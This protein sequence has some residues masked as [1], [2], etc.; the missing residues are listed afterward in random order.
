MS[1]LA[2]YEHAIAV[3]TMT[4]VA[5]QREVL[6]H[7]QR[8]ADALT[9][10][11]RRFP[12]QRLAQIQGIYLHGPV[13]SGK[14][15]LVDMLLQQLQGVAVG[16]FHFHQFMQQ[17]DA[18]L[19]ALQ[20]QSDPLRRIVAQYAKTT[21]LLCL[22]EF[23][24]Q[25]VAHAMMLAELLKALAAHEVVLVATSNTAPEN[26]YLNGVQRDR[27]LPAIALLQTH[28]EVLELVS[29]Q[30]F[31]LK[32]TAGSGTWYMLDE[33]NRMREA[34]FERDP[35]A[36]KDVM[37]N[38]QNRP[39]P[40]RYCGA[41][42]VWFAFDT[43]YNLPRSTL[44]YL[45]IAHRFDTVFIDELPDPSAMSSTQ[46]LLFA[47]CMDVFYDNGVRMVVR[48]AAR[49]DAFLMT[50]PFASA[51]QRTASRLQEMQSEAYFFNHLAR[52]VDVL[53]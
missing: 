9:G 36:E 17:V 7:F 43:L 16:R 10:T 38:V 14:T 24:V 21:R 20:G 15:S 39:I 22:D 4:D 46:C 18:R 29:G 53:Q 28:C 44:D 5:A 8:L 50:E 52:R 34:F 41:S 37:L 2:A 27:F 6:A 33:E 25:D 45:E 11:R 48:S 35:H 30:D 13:G 1:L 42:S 23:L 12:W 49:P 40:A 19:R 3:G 32:N 31:R 47:Q 51:W 26:L